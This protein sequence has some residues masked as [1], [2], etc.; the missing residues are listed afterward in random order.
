MGQPIVQM[1][2]RLVDTGG[3]G[4]INFSLFEDPDGRLLGMWRQK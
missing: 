3:K 4:G 1:N 2:Y